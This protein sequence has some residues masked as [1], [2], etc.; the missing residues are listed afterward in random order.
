[1]CNRLIITAIEIRL[2]SDVTAR[3]YFPNEASKGFKECGFFR[4]D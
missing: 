3:W 2:N 1:M 4:K